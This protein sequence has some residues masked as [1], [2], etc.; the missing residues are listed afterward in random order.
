MTTAIRAARAG[1]SPPSLLPEVVT[2]EDQVLP[3]A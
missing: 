3:A 2:S 1:Q